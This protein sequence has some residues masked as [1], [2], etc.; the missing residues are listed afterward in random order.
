[1]L[2]FSN[3]KPLNGFFKGKEFVPGLYIFG[4]IIGDHVK[5]LN[6]YYLKDYVQA[7]MLETVHAPEDLSGILVQRHG[8][9]YKEK[10]VRH[11]D[12]RKF[13]R[14]AIEWEILGEVEAR[15]ATEQPDLTNDDVMNITLDLAELQFAEADGWNWSYD[16]TKEEFEPGLYLICVNT[17]GSFLEYYDNYLLL[18]DHIS[19]YSPRYLVKIKKVDLPSFEQN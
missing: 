4:K 16:F 6:A 10:L 13:N 18:I 5:E 17:I 1:M 3:W 19:Y 7:E 14:Q 12:R 11:K 9:Y 15:M 8:E 2:D